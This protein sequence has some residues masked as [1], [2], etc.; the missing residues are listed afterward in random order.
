MDSWV[1]KICWRKDRLPTLADLGSIPRLGK[2]SGD[3]KGYGLQH[4]GL[5]NSVDYIVHGVTNSQTRLSNFHFHMSLG[6]PGSR[7]E[8]T[9][10]P[11]QEMQ[12]MWVQFGSGKSPEEGNGNSLQYS[13]LENLINRGAFWARV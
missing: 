8:K 2:S 10:L 11:M 1:R 12:E 4:S 6:F 7:V 13:C 9:Q 5:D 3:G